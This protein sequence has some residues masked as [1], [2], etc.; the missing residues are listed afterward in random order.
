MSQSARAQSL[1]SLGTLDPV[2]TQVR[3][4]AE[5]IVHREPELASLVVSTVLHHSSLEEAVAH[6]IATRLE[7]AEMN[8]SAIRQA[9][10]DAL[11]GDPD[12]GLAMRADIVAVLDR[13]P[14]SAR[15]IE[16]VLY[17]KGFHAIQAQRLAHRLWLQGRRDFALF[18]QSRM[19]AALQVDIHPETRI[20]KGVFID[21]ATGVVIGAT[22]VIEDEVSIL[23][24]VTL[25]GTGKEHGD[26]HPKIRKGSLIGA[27]AKILGNIEVGPNSR[28]AAGSVVL[29]SVPPCTTVAGVPARVIGRAPCDEPS[30]SMDHTLEGIE[31]FDPVI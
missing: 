18:L 21:H 3:K 15:A 14:A 1:G 6:R 25:G 20:G 31:Y 5:E 16:P 13:D 12:I 9:F 4:E 19:S 28:V 17:F 10:D 22:A 30:L 29:K 2:W 11:A 7:H 27:G 26:R 24:S 23:Q 8:A